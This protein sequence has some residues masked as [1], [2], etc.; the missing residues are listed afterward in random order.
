MSL[1]ICTYAKKNTTLLQYLPQWNEKRY[2]VFLKKYI[3]QAEYIRVKII[4]LTNFQKSEKLSNRSNSIH[5][6]IYTNKNT[7]TPQLSH[8]IFRSIWDQLNSNS[9]VKNCNCNCNRTNLYICYFLKHTYLNWYI[10]F[11]L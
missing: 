5:T 3:Y 4:K 2:V 11:L 7:R 9:L 10:K 1:F 6:N 8:Y